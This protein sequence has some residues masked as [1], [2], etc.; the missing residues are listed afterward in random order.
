MTLSVILEFVAVGTVL[1]GG[2]MWKGPRSQSVSQAKLARYRWATL[3]SAGWALIILV[4]LLT[5]TYK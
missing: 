4:R 2:Y 3:F 1:V 5:H